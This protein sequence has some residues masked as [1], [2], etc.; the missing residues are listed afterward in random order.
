M[1]RGLLNG[2]LIF[3][4]TALWLLNRERK[5]SWPLF[6]PY[7]LDYPSSVLRTFRVA[8]NPN[9]ASLTHDDAIWALGNN[10]I[11]LNACSGQNE[12]YVSI[13]SMLVFIHF[14]LRLEINKISIETATGREIVT[15]A[16]CI[17][18]EFKPFFV[19]PV[20]TDIHTHTYGRTPQLSISTP[21]R[22]SFF[23]ILYLNSIG[24]NVY[25]CASKYE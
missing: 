16:E 8:P 19:L 22:Y 14:G 24:K 13:W 17:W 23:S 20:R 9:A 2:T 21:F 5:I 1:D 7:I 6:Y 18:I 12:Y 15:I 10:L 11:A 3:V 25:G 4:N